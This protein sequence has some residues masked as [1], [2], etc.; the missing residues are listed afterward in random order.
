[1]T[2]V[3]NGYFFAF[4]AQCS[5]GDFECEIFLDETVADRTRRDWQ[6][7]ALVHLEKAV[8]RRLQKWMSVRNIGAGHSIQGMADHEEFETTITRKA[9]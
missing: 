9:G 3:Q 2:R 7:I 5:L 6:S 8:H 4:S 1:M